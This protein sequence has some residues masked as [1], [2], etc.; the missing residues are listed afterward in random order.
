[1]IAERLAR[2]ASERADKTALQIKRGD[3]WH[4]ITYADLYSRCLGIASML[5]ESGVQPG[6]RVAL[7][8]GNSPEWL[9]AYLGIHFA[10]AIV[11]PL[12]CQYGAKELANLLNFTEAEAIL[13]DAAGCKVLEQA[14]PELR[15]AVRK[16]VMDAEQKDNWIYQNPPSGFQPHSFQPDDVMSIIFTSGT[17]GDPKGVQLTVRNIVSNI[18]GILKKIK[19]TA[20]DNILNILPLH[21]AYAS[22]A[23]AFSPLYAGA[24]VT[25]CLSLKGPDLMATLQETGV[26]IFPGVPQLFT[27]FDRAI[28][29]KIAASGLLTRILFYSLFALSAAVRKAA[30]I[31]LGKY[32]FGKVHRQFGSRLRF[33]VSGGAKL[34]PPVAERLLNLGVLMLEGYGLTETSPVISFT[35]PDKP[36]PGSV[37]LPLEGVEI[38]IHQ[39][40]SSGQG[41]ICIRGANVMKGYYK[42]D[43]ATREVIRDGWLHTGDLGFIDTDGMLI[44]TGRAKEMIVLPSGKNI[45]PDELEVR[46]QGTP[47][48]KE[49]CI[50]QMNDASGKPEG[51]CAVV[52]ADAEEL[53][54][55]KVPNP[56]ERIRSELAK[57]GASL[58]SFMRLTDLVLFPEALP[59][60][61]LGKLRRTRIAEEVARLKRQSHSPETFEWTPE[62]KQLMEHPSSKRFLKRLA[63][64][65]GKPGP[66]LPGQ[67]LEMD[68]GM[69][70]LTRVQIGAVLEREFQVM[71]PDE[72]VANV[73]TVGDVLQRITLAQSREELIQETTSLD[74]SNQLLEKPRKSLDE[75]FNMKR[76]ILANTGIGIARAILRIVV[77]FLFRAKIEGLEKLPREG[78]LLICPNHQSYAD[79]VLI[80]TLMPGWLIRRTLF[81]GFQDIFARPPLSWVARVG[82]IILTGSAETLA[83]SLKLSADGLRRGMAVCLFP[84]GARSTNGSIL[85][86]RPGAAILSSELQTPIVPVLI[87]GALGTLSPQYPKLRRCK[88][89]LFVGEP[90]LPPPL[91][92]E[93]KEQIYQSLMNDWRNR[94]LEMQKQLGVSDAPIQDESTHHE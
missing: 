11:V 68:L 91:P 57:T 84:E 5:C 48:V 9:I 53:A 73:R 59:R 81:I 89:R 34:D 62:M 17:T 19:V 28:F 49:I 60:T 47:L 37:G 70:S 27:L 82:R 80:F 29:Q 79:A 38:R 41:E 86:P 61:R 51:L 3:D 50:I 40:D 22:T 54:A 83:E 18:E 66:F 36:K 74:W 65:T 10:G 94:L 56:R 45:Y 26:T 14:Q 8:A 52:V 76:G 58:P 71:I 92:Q 42:N 78:A 46:Y 85:L 64:I 87:D 32:F 31:R 20:K 69:D 90:I 93:S 39:P 75:M 2:N 13:L 23:G 63:D 12:D 55:R 77:F 25:F 15:K 43:Q 30:G 7:F 16:W 67:D 24:T 35:P 21:H 33:F 44:I 4:K 1:M 88:I 6:D 72:E